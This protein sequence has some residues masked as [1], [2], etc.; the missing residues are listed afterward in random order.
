MAVSLKET[1]LNYLLSG[2]SVGREAQGEVCPAQKVVIAKVIGKA[3]LDEG[4]EGGDVAQ[5]PCA[6]WLRV[7]SQLW[8]F[9]QWM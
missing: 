7:T 5:L 4:H 2:F 3:R 6:R 8:S 1:P 9:F